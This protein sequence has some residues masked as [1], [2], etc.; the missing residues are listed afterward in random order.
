VIRA[1]LLFASAAE[2]L[3]RPANPNRGHRADGIA[4]AG[5]C[6]IRLP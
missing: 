5:R 4:A 2:T 3:Q 6:A 1:V